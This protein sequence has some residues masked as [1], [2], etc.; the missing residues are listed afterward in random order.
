MKRST[1]D[2]VISTVTVVI[3]LAVTP[4]LSQL[5]PMTGRANDANNQVGSGGFNAPT[6]RT[7]FNTGNLYMTGN[8]TGGKSF[9]GYSPIHGSNSL[10]LNL[11]STTYLGNFQRDSV[12]LSNTI[13][14]TTFG[15]ATP[16]YNPASTVTNAGAIGAGLNRPG[17]SIP[18]NSFSRS[19]A[20]CEFNRQCPG[21]Y[22]L[23]DSAS[24]QR[25]LRTARSIPHR[26]CRFCAVKTQS[27]ISA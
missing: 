11:P 18:Q 10:F 17:M 22:N 23:W 14:P 13:R 6:Q 24:E 12:G 20:R 1:I 2:L 9:R 4:A 16:Y 3:F 26:T 25:C 7:F 27:I 19:H 15:L 21:G 8:V 5:Q